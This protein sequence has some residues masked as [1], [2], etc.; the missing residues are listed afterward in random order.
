MSVLL[1]LEN[2]SKEYRRG[3]LRLPVLERVS[4]DLTEGEVVA[5]L[6]SRGQG[7]STLLRVAAGMER[8]EHGR[9]LLDGEDLWGVAD[10]RRQ[11]L[12]RGLVGWVEVA[13]PDL[14]VQVGEL[15]AMPLL[16]ARGAREASARVEAVLARVGALECVGMRW[17]VL[18]DRERALV[19]LAQG[20]VRGPRLLLV[21]DLTS[22]LGLGETD[23]V[24]G[25]VHAVAHESNVG[26]LMGVA[27]GGATQWSDRIATLACGE[28]LVPS[29]GP[30]DGGGE[31]IDLRPMGSVGGGG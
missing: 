28:L 29:R 6:G 30:G 19:A 1:S 9:V 14:D 12:L 23:E 25:L 18:S 13:A 17:G 15:I 24:T 3:D 26:V 4:L 8:P 2:V 11:L 27:D 21:D 31:L 10:A 7:K 5:V 16:V 22:P 20:L